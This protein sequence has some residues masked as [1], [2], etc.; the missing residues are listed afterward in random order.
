MNDEINKLE[1]SS[2]SDAFDHP[3]IDKRSL[4]AYKRAEKEQKRKLKQ[5]RLEQLNKLI[6]NTTDS[7]E[8][9]NYKKEA[10]ELE[11][12]LNKALKET[13]SCTVFSEPVQNSE[14]KYISDLMYLL[15][16]NTIE[17]FI[18]YLDHNNTDLQFFEDLVLFNLS[19][20]IK[21]NNDEIGLDLT[22]ISLYVK[23]AKSNGRAFLTELCKSF[24]DERKK[25]LFEEECKDH[26]KRA[27]EAILSLNKDA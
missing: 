10:N 19:E 6:E 25:E 22:R 12:N 18:Q 8:L 26:Y 20:N 15:N 3:N 9:D 23:F 13:E 17:H 27:K 24:R 2:D 5:E 11:R 7:I 21:E 14:D 1:L 4:I 16:N